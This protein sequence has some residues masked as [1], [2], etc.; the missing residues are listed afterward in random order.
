VQWSSLRVP[1]F[2]HSVLT[3]LTLSSGYQRRTQRQEALGSA[4]RQGL[5]A[6]TIPISAKA[7]WRGGINLVYRAEWRQETSESPAS[8]TE[9]MDRTQSA[10]LNG[11]LRLP[12][13]FSR[14]L[15]GP[16]SLDLSYTQGDRLECRISPENPECAAES[17][18]VRNRERLLRFEAATRVG[19]LKVGLRADYLG[20]H[21]LIGERNGNSQFNAGLFGEFDLSTT[22]QSPR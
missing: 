9:R 13:A 14:Y 5:D 11:T 18:F 1:P 10:S 19:L 2:L 22:S 16:L 6:T 15:R 3:G 8:A 7:A 20:R 17:E 12:E 4:H 21:S